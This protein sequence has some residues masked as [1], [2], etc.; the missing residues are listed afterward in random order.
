MSILDQKGQPL[1]AAA[2]QALN[3]YHEPA[4]YASAQLGHYIAQTLHDELEAYAERH[5][6]ELRQVK[7]SLTT[8]KQ[9]PAKITV[10]L[11]HESNGVK[12]LGYPTRT[13]T[14]AVERKE[15]NAS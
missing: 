9:D 4:M 3:R 11:S 7:F 14:M 5:H 2:R 8:Y 6:L 12:V 1:E 15:S 10:T 13:I